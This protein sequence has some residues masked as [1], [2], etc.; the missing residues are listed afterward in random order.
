LGRGYGNH[1]QF[2]RDLRVALG[3]NHELWQ[4]VDRLQKLRIQADYQFDAVKR[5]YEGDPKRFQEE[6]FKGLALGLEAYK[7]MLQRVSREQE[8]NGPN[9]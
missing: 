9:Y 2:L 1:D 6:A 4:K 3:S 8:E 7:D 5:N